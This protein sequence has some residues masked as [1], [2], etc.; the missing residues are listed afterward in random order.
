MPSIRWSRVIL[1]GL[2]AGVVVNVFEYLLN[3]VLLAQSWA[4]AMG[5]LNR[6]EGFSSVQVVAFNVWGFL[7]GIGAVWLYAS[8]RDH[9]GPGIR[10][11]L[12]AGV[13]VWAIGY[14][15]G[16]IPSMALHMFPR[17]LMTYGVLMG[18]FEMAA[19]TVLGAW[20]YRPAA[21][22]VTRAAA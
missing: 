22:A 8:I 16:M 13:A 9:Y 1:G 11:A 5:S 6:P 20:I 18:L 10:T 4:A 15:F 21:P 19:G 17:R 7:M 14:A 2:A 3:G 12:C